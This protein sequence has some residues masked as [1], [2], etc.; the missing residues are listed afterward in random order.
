M[1]HIRRGHLQEAKVVAP[2]APLLGQADEVIG[3][4]YDLHAQL[5]IESRKLVTMRNYL[6]PKLLS[7]N[8][9]VEAAHG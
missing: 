5:M 8:V 9:R 3:S 2:P 1:G 4:L 7:G 6:L